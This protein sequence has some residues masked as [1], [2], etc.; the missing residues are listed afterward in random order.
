MTAGSRAKQL[1]D[2]HIRELPLAERLQLLALLAR[3]LA[4]RAESLT[5]EPPHDIMELY[6]VGKTRGIGM[7]AQEY[8]D[9]LRQGRSLSPDDDR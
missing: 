9:R 1:Y 7:D 4:A 3:D 2:E 8:I 6:G 5:D